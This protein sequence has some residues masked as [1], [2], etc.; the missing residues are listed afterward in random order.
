MTGSRGALAD[1]A[2]PI[3][4]PALD[5]ELRRLHG[6]GEAAALSALHVHAAELMPSPEGRRFHLTH[7]WIYALVAGDP[8]ATVKLEA[9]LR[10]MGGL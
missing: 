7:A 10:S 5:A 8:F 3:S 9:E 1:I 4:A 6:S 2:Q